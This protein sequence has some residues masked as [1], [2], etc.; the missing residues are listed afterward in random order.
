[1]KWI[2]FFRLMPM[3]FI[4]S[5]LLEIHFYGTKSDSWARFCLWLAQ[6]KKNPHWLLSFWILINFQKNL[7]IRW[8]PS[9]LWS[10]R[11][12]NILNSSLTLISRLQLLF[13]KR[14]FCFIQLQLISNE[15]VCRKNF[16]NKLYDYGSK[17][18]DDFNENYA[19]AN[20]GR[21]QEN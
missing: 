2:K 11:I 9:I 10:C 12:V 5:I 15:K 14:T 17:R 6:G 21:V 1:M 4:T 19:I 8:L 20:F 16:D 18:S 7:I 3:R 13:I